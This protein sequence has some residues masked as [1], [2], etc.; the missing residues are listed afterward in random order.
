MT[1]HL[2][3][4]SGINFFMPVFSFIFVSVI[5]YAILTKTEILGEGNTFIN[6]VVSFIM[7][8][9]FMSVTSAEFYVKT[10]I[11]WFVVLFIMVFLVLLVAGLSTGDLE[12]IKSTRFAWI[13]VIILIAIFIISAI[14]VFNPVFHPDLIIAEGA[15][16][17]GAVSQIRDYFN[18]PSGQSGG[19]V[20][21]IVIGLLAW[22]LTKSGGS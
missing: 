4:I 12:K 22:V 17:P 21:I 1:S 18:Y 10:I 19:I 16:G 20:L 5:I 6:L 11:P 15:E 7:A 14:R 9:V 2:I 8:I 3:D 13:I